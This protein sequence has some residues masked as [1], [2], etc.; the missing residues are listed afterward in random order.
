LSRV[1]PF[2]EERGETGE[3]GE[4]S[5]YDPNLTFHCVSGSSSCQVSKP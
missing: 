4:G 5:S 2:D 3:G 1:T